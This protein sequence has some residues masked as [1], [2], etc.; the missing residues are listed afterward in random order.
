MRVYFVTRFSIYDPQFRGFRLTT[1]HNQKEYERRLFS[2]DRLQN[3]FETFQTITFPSIV[4]Q[5]CD[6]WKWLIYTSDQMPYEYMKRLRTLVKDY[7][8]IALIT[9]R[10]FDEFFEAHRTLDYGDSFATVRIDD[11]DGV[12]LSF[13]E[14]LQQYSSS[15]GSIVSFTEGALV[16]CANGRMIVGDA[17]SQ[18]NSALGLSGIGVKIYSCG[19]HSDI[20]ARY[21][22]IY[23]S[24]PGMYFLCCS[25]FADTQRGFTPFERVLAKFRRLLFLILHRPT[26]AR[27]ECAQFVRKRLKHQAL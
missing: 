8:S 3:K 5:S 13:V 1:D 21:N 19:R 4:K 11:D 10:N 2:R 15:V 6:D 16:G 18:K 9:V 27:R 25:P 7:P 12:S 17:V 23:D 24:T 22:V 20:H 14:K 26:E